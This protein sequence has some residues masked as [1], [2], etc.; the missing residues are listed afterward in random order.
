MGTRTERVRCGHTTTRLC[1]KPETQTHPHCRSNNGVPL[2]DEDGQRQARARRRTRRCG[3]RGGR[4]NSGG[5]RRERGHGKRGRG[6]AVSGG[7][8]G[9]TERHA[10][11]TG[12]SQTKANK[13]KRRTHSGAHTSG[14]RGEGAR[15]KRDTGVRRVEKKKMEVHATRAGTEPHT[16][17]QTPTRESTEMEEGERGGDEA[18]IN[19]CACVGDTDAEPSSRKSHLKREC[20]WRSSLSSLFQQAGASDGH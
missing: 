4:G 12:A 5:S 13:D 19:S 10:N 9:P 11:A 17:T 15:G 3:G 7:V 14:G 16:H 18:R 1:R 2:Y 6:E 20:N 8:S